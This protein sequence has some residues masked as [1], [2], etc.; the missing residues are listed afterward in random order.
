MPISWVRQQEGLTG[1]QKLNKEGVWEVDK[2]TVEGW[3]EATYKGLATGATEM[4]SEAV[5]EFLPFGRVFSVI[6]KVTR[7]KFSPVRIP[8]LA[9]ILK[10]AKLNSI[11]AEAKKKPLRDMRRV[12]N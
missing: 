5:G 9:G 10:T 2:K 11:P 8:G 1:Q 12:S 4:I 6:K 3:L 7:V